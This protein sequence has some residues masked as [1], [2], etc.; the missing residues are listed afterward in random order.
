MK[1]DTTPPVVSMTFPANNTDYGADAWTTGGGT[2]CGAI[3]TICGQATDAT[4]GISGPGSIS[5][6]ITQSG[7]G[8]TWNGTAFASG[9]NV[10]N[11][12][13][14]DACSGLW[15]Y[16][17]A[18][19]NFGSDGNVPRGLERHGSRGQY[20]P[21]FDPYLRH[22]HHGASPT[23]TSPAEGAY[24]SKTNPTISGTSGTQAANSS[25]SADSTTVTV[26]IFTELTAIGSP[27]Q[28]F[29]AVAVS[30]GALVSERIGT[31][32]ERAVHR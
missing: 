10:V 30:G 13:T 15:T 1:V 22:R 23:V 31:G 8:K 4:G 16:T 12:I 17:F 19:S 3:N 27:I 25:N 7:S 28:T 29:N 14:Y 20:D 9:V 5:L 2:P 26:K 24:T 6:T 11:P 21:G 18:T 32:G